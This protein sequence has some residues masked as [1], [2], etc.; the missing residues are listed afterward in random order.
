M[1]FL[2]KVSWFVLYSVVSVSVFFLYSLLLVGS[3][4]Y[5][6]VII[7]AMNCLE[8]YPLSSNRQHLSY[9]G[10]LEVRGEIIR[11]VSY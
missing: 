10:C 11:T 9:D 2:V 5:I 6:F 4:C 7:S 8:I 3:G 1:F